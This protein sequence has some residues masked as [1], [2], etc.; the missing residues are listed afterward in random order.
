MSE[1]LA[2]GRPVQIAPPRQFPNHLIE[3]TIEGG[4]ESPGREPWLRSV[5]HG[6]CLAQA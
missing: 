1:V 4:Q 6:A 2:G 5:R 3:C